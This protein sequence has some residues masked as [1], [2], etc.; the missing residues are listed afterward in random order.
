MKYLNIIIFN[1]VLKLKIT[2]NLKNI[3]YPEKCLLS[4]IFN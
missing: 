2:R 4:M 1:I 3:L